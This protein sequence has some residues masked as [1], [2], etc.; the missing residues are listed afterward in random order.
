LHAG[1]DNAAHM[2][3][4]YS[5]VNMDERARS[6]HTRVLQ[7]SAEMTTRVAHAVA[8]LQE[9]L[10]A[11]RLITARSRTLCARPRGPWGTTLRDPRATP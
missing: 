3:A 8:D 9:A 7:D 4:L 10:R 5:H 11:S 2:I 1:S 6:T